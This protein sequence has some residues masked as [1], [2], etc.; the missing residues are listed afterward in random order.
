M[1]VEVEPTIEV[2]LEAGDGIVAQYDVVFSI[3]DF[4]IIADLGEALQKTG[5]MASVMVAFDKDDVAIEAFEDVDGG[6]HITPEHVAKDIDS[7]A[8]VDGGV[9]STYE[10]F[11][12]LASGFEGAIV[13]EE[14]VG[15]VIVPVSNIQFAWFHSF[16]FISIV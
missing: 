5:V 13:E 1:S 15:V 6:R 9:P 8:G 2:V 4:E 14:N 11:V 7:V 16:S 10:F 3:F 12:M